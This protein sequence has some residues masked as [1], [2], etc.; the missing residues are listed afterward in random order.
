MMSPP[1]PHIGYVV[2]R[3]PRYSETFIVNEILSHERAGSK[4][5]IFA[6]RPPNDTHFQDIIAKVKAPVHYLP[7][8]KLKAET[9]VSMMAKWV[10]ELPSL[11]HYLASNLQH[12]PRELMQAA[13][14][15]DQVQTLGIT[16]LHA[17]FATYPAEVTRLA[18]LFAGVTYSFTAH[19]VDI[20]HEITRTE[21]LREKFSDA[22]FSVTVSDYNINYLHNR[23][24]KISSTIHR[25]YNGM[26][27]AQFKWHSPL[28]RPPEIITVGRMVEK[29]GFRYLI[30]AC[31]LL[32][33]KGV[34]FRC[35][36][37]GM[38]ELS[39]SLAQ[40]VID[41]NLQDV[42]ELTG[43]VPQNEV[44]EAIKS[45]AVFAAPCIVADDGNRDGLPT[46]ILE[47][48]ALG[49]P[50]VST[51]VTGIPEVIKHQQTG[52]Q[53]P[54]HDAESLASALEVLL[55]DGQLRE[56]LSRQAR[57]LI[58]ENFDVDRNTALIRKQFS[59]V[60]L[61]SA[62]ALRHNPAKKAA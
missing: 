56:K 59:A 58:E 6:L 4:I 52:Y 13:Y 39:E 7:Y 30:D 5:D 22:A 24:G 9:W 35:R 29:K 60:A 12:G 21:D 19:A 10:K 49:T 17:H 27:L 16:H 45:A 57:Q 38:G 54:Q 62:A 33:Q 26:D 46:V 47:S 43:P 28:Q 34:E 3:Y 42:V 40:Q 8:N 36:M 31:E 48:M 32:K 25:I 44:R 15:A 55:K 51:D 37:I 11:K 18:A 53:V 20:F 41:K 61:L 23:L 1:E 14:L 50:C 2:K